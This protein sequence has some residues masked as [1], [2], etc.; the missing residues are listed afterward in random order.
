MKQPF[1]FE[2]QQ[3]LNNG[4]DAVMGTVCAGLTT[5]E[6]RRLNP[7]LLKAAPELLEALKAFDH[8]LCASYPY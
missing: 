5:D 6:L 7:K 8:Y 3:D 2:H 1:T 4:R